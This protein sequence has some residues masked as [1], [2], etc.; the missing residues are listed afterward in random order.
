MDTTGYVAL[1]HQ[2]ALRRHLDIIANNIANAST[3]AYRRESVMFQDY[4]SNMPEAEVSSARPVSFV[5]DYGVARDPRPGDMIPTDNPLDIGIHGAGYFTVRANDGQPAYTRNGAL[6]PS[7]DGFLVIASGE[8]VL[9]TQNQLIAL[10]PEEV[11]IKIANDGTISTN[12]GVKGQLL[13]SNLPE[14][15][16]LER[17]GNGLWRGAN[18][19]AIPTNEVKLKSGMVEGSNVQPVMEMSEMID[20]L[21]TYQSTTRLMDRYDDIRKS[22]IERLGRVQ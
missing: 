11:D 2:M 13:I 16:D 18:A 14:S 10:S 8:R 12:L 19:T 5:L 6:R 15:Q 9:N 20:V 1:S 22:G 3:N 4:M 21:R 7:P 17:M